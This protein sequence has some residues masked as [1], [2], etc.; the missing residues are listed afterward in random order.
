MKKYFKSLILV[1]LILS[2][3]VGGLSCLDTLMSPTANIY[4][5]NEGVTCSVTYFNDQHS[6]EEDICKYVLN[7]LNNYSS[8]TDSIKEGVKKIGKTYGI[9]DLNVN[10]DS[11]LGENK[12]C[13]VYDVEGTSMVPTLRDGQSIIVEKTKDINVNDVVIANSSKYGIIVKRVSEIKGNNIHLISDNKN[14]EYK[15]INGQIYEFK[16]ITTWVDISKIYGVVKL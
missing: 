9:N 1:I 10:I 7:Q 5:D 14:I 2:V 6:L 11:K 4:T 3:I 13:M 16:G 15:T 12:L 8:N